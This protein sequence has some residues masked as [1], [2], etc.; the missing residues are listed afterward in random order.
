MVASEPL[1][2][3]RSEWLE[4]PEYCLLVAAPD[5]DRLSV[6]MRELDA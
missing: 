2:R 5:G 1:T 4:A 3:D 6:D